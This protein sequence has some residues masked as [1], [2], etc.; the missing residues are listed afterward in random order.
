VEELAEAGSPTAEVNKEEAADEE[1]RERVFELRAT[2]M[3]PIDDQG[4]V[5]E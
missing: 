1:T 2:S 4:K 5:A 3:L